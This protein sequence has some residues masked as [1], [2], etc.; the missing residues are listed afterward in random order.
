VGQEPPCGAG[1]GACE[2][3]SMPF[4]YG[5]SI[6]HRVKPLQ[7][8]SPEDKGLTPTLGFL[9]KGSCTGKTRLRNIWL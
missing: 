7:R 1:P 3:V 6:S 5:V 2:T 8:F 9:A 4:K